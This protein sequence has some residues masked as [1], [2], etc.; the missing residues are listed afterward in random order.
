[1]FTARHAA[2][3]P[4]E[5]TRSGGNAEPSPA[6]DIDIHFPSLPAAARPRP[7]ALI[8]NTQAA[9]AA[10]HDGAQDTER[11]STGI[12]F[13]FEAAFS[14]DDEACR[15]PPVDGETDPIHCAH[16]LTSI[17]KDT[18]TFVSRFSPPWHS[19]L[20]ALPGALALPFGSHAIDIQAA[21]GAP[22]ISGTSPNTSMMNAPNQKDE[23]FMYQA[24]PILTA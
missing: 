22:S 9:A 5:A 15:S 17:C 20:I 18:H 11:A 23:Y 8:A 24:R 2:P 19:V 16:D 4:P 1:M 3:S 7:V 12:E 21:P 10:M 6:A 13:P 14:D